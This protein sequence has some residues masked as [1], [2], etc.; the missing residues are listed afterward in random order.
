MKLPIYNGEGI[1]VK[2]IDLSDEVFGLE[3]NADLV[4]QVVTS[5]LGNARENIAH[6]KNR[7]EVSGGGIKPWR[8]K[9]TGRARHGSIRSPLWVG[10]GITFGP[11][12]DRNFKTK[13]NKKMKSKSLAIVLSQKI[14]DN[15][16]ILVDK[17]NFEEPKTV[18]AKKILIAL[19]K[20]AGFE[21]L[22]TKRKNAA[23]I[24]L[25]DK[26][27]NLIKSFKNFNNLEIDEVRN[28]NPAT[29][30]NYKYVLILD[31]ENSIKTL[32]QRLNKDN[33]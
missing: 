28:F 27:F 30:L 18:S 24:G 19:D 14:R 32:E 13:V 2:K 1:E 21:K 33:K 12:N 15:E 3:W 22:S 26:D 17:L 4:H 10:G 7:G 16:L 25:N 5:L 20:T 29:L 9:G 31:A 8:Q 6:T 11:R 23:L